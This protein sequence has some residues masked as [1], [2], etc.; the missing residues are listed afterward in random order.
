MKSLDTNQGFF[1]FQILSLPNEIMIIYGGDW[2][3][4][5]SIGIKKT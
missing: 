2:R 3:Y 1:C 5:S 4:I